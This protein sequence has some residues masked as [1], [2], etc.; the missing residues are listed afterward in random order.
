MMSDQLET[1][2]AIFHDDRTH[3]SNGVILQVGLSQDGNTLRCQVNLLPENRQVIAEVTWDDIGRITFPEANDLCIVAFCDGAPEEAHIVRIKTTSDAGE[4]ISKFAQGGHTI[5]NSRQGKKNYVG[6]DTKVGLGRID[7]EPT[8]PLV[9]GNVLI[10]AL[11]ALVNA[12]LTVPQIGQCSVGPVVLDG[13]VIAALNQFVSTYVTAPGSNIVSQIVF[14]ERGKMSCRKP[15]YVALIQEIF[16]DPGNLGESG[17]A[18]FAA[19]QNKLAQLLAALTTFP[20]GIILPFGGT[21]APTG[22]LLCDGSAVSR[23]TYSSLFAIIGDNFGQGDG[24]TTFNLPRGW[25]NTFRGVA[26]I[27]GVSSGLPSISGSGSVIAT[28]NVTFTG[29]GFYAGQRVRMVSGSLTGL[30]IGTDYYVG[31]VDANT[32]YF[33]TSIGNVFGTNTTTGGTDRGGQDINLR[34]KY[35][36]PAGMARSRCRFALCLIPRWRN[37][38]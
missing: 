17:E 1:L 15:V 29:H 14:T 36:R 20:S 26:P 16:P 11:Q 2:R 35:R 5:T 12:F 23:A 33:S 31:V 19:S 7:V 9:L 22:Y 37:W 27:P 18:S 28:N 21:S 38:K 8:E 30:T 4:G 13:S 6:S 32:L 24:S 10:S 25:G 34:N 3:L